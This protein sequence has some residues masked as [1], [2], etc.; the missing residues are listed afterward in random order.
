MTAKKNK[1]CNDPVTNCAHG[2]A[3]CFLQRL[4]ATVGSDS[5]LF[6]PLFVSIQ[7]EQEW[8]FTFGMSSK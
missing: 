2:F 6:Q 3:D 7:V 5:W 8:N 1:I 4:P